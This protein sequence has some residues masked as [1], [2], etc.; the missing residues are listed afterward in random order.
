MTHYDCMYLIPKNIYDT[1]LLSINEHEKKKV[2]KLNDSD[3]GNLSG[4]FPDIPD[5]PGTPSNS[6]V[7]N[8]DSSS[9]SNSDNNDSSNNDNNDDNL[10]PR[11]TSTVTNASSSDHSEANSALSSPFISPVRR[12]HNDNYYSIAG[13]TRLDELSS[14]ADA[15]TTRKKKSKNISKELKKSFV[16]VQSTSGMQNN[17]ILELTLNNQSVD[18]R[19]VGMQNNPPPL[20]TPNIS[21]N[22][23]P[24]LSTPIISQ[25]SKNKTSTPKTKSPQNSLSQSAKDKS[26]STEENISM[27][28]SS[29]TENTLSK[30]TKQKKFR[31]TICKE[32][33]YYIKDLNLH[34]NTKHHKKVNVKKNVY[35]NWSEEKNAKSTLNSD[36]EEMT[37]SNNKNVLSSDDEVM[38]NVITSTSKKNDLIDFSSDNEN[39]STQTVTIPDKEGYF[40]DNYDISAKQCKLCP[41]YFNNEKSLERHIH[42]IHDA[43]KHYISWVNHGTKRKSKNVN[44]N[45]KKNKYDYNTEKPEFLCDLCDIAFSNKKSFE[46]HKKNIH[47]TD[48][49]YVSWLPQGVKRKNNEDKSYQQTK[50]FS[51]FLHKCKLCPHTFSKENALIRHIKNLHSAN[52]KYI[53][54]LEQGE[55]RKR[56]N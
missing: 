14:D 2:E 15:S 22:N 11:N 4:A 38:S 49:D 23:P 55:K 10:S 21:Q 56:V 9:S 5:T 1:F 48:K 41:A 17:K 50:K 35:P 36:D 44:K 20:S 32:L 52:E 18:D 42:N 12:P 27:T 24:P 31:C 3:I 16:P 39:N 51:K 6:T 53:S 46:R 33:F 8:N 37:I 29:K 28:S 7:S 54:E 25:N 43:D 34:L 13:I 45:I 30:K 47:S 19:L 40:Y 26:N